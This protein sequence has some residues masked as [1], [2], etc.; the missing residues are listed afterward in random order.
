MAKGIVGHL[1]CIRRLAAAWLRASSIVGHEIS[2][3]VFGAGRF[4]TWESKGGIRGGL[5]GSTK[6]LG[7]AGSSIVMVVSILWA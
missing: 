4:G 7:I 3:G 1:H 6:S 5:D 2:V